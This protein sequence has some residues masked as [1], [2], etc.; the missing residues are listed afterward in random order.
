MIRIIANF[1][2]T[3][4]NFCYHGNKDRF[5]NSNESVENFFRGHVG[6]LTGSMRAKFKVRT[7]SHFGAVGITP[8]KLKFT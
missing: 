2:S 6:T 3:F 5:F 4:P 7:L 8:K 1:V